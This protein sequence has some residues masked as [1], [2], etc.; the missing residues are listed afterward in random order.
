MTCTLTGSLRINGEAKVV[1]LS[2]DL[3][4]VNKI[5]NGSA[6]DVAPRCE[7]LNGKDY[8]ESHLLGGAN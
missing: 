7:S 1:L 4:K 5:I 3:Y 2:V 8:A 6:L